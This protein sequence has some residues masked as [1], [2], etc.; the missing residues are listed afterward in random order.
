MLTNTIRHAA[1]GINVASTLSLELCMF[2]KPVINIGYNPPG[3]E[4][5]PVEYRRYYDFDHYRPIVEKWGRICGIF[6]KRT[7]RD[8]TGCFDAAGTAKRRAKDSTPP[9]VR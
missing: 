8:A 3:T 2:D 9:N 7:S 4:V 5:S 1:V 6:G